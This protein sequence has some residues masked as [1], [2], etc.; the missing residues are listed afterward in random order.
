MRRSQLC[1]TI[2]GNN[3][4]LLQITDFESDQE[5][6]GLKKGI[7][8]SARVHPGET[9][10]SYVMEGIIRFL[11]GQSENAKLL[12][13]K[14]VFKIVPMLNIDG[15]VNGNYRCNLSGVDLNR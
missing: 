8:L 4:Y 10:N 7:I 2:A 5:E 11:T 13:Q 6:D 12:R 14:F 3:C 9:S 1:E 15:V